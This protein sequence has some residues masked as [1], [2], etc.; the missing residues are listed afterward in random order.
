MKVIPETGRPH[1]EGNLTTTNETYPWSS[2][3]VI[4]SKGKPGHDG[5]RD[6]LMFCRSLFVLCSLSFD[7]CMVC[8]SSMYGF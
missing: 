3:T 1:Q 5:D 4:F 8:T 2:V 7:N 6:D